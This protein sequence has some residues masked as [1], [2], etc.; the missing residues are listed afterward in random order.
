FRSREVT[1]EAFFALMRLLG[2]VGHR[3]PRRRGPVAHSYVFRFRRLP[4]GWPP[5]WGRFFRGISGEA[6]EDL[7][8]RLLDHASARARSAAI[9]EHLQA[10]RRFFDDEARALAE[11]IAATGYP[12]YPVPQTERDALFLRCRQRAANHP[13][14]M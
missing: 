2:I 11:A 3:A 12:S 13:A 5:L 9:Q 10:A 6:L 1:R 4:G 7:S 8:L 14:R